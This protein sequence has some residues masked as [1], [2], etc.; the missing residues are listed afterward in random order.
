MKLSNYNFPVKLSEDKTVLFNTITNKYAL[1]EHHTYD[2]LDSD[3]EE[4]F[5]SHPEAAKDL[6]ENGFLVKESVNE[7]LKVKNDFFARAYNSSI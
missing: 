7:L 6:L 3:C 2:I 1:F 4:Y 5:I